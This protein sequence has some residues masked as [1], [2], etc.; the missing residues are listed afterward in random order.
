MSKHNHTLEWHNEKRKIGELLPY[1][2]NPRK[3]TEKQK[4]DLMKSLQK[5]NLAEVPA[6]NTDNLIIA[7]HQRLSI[8]KELYGSDYEIDVRVPSRQ[9]SEKEFQEYNIRSNKNVGEWDFDVLANAFDLE[10]L[11]EWGFD[12]EQFETTEINDD[13]EDKQ[14][15]ITPKKIFEIVIECENEE[16]QEKIYNEISETYR[17]RILTY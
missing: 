13:H 2:N 5:F 17:C 12:A 16:E 10:D 15:E 8:L 4:K 14:K 7:G 11:T 9:L 6:I 3:I 1:E